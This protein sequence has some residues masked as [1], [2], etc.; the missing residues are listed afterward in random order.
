MEFSP[1][2]KDTGY[3]PHSRSQPLNQPQGPKTKIYT[4]HS[5][6]TSILYIIKPSSVALIHVSVPSDQSG[7]RKSAQETP[8]RQ[9]WSPEGPKGLPRVQIGVP[10]GPPGTPRGVHF[11]PWS[12]LTIHTFSRASFGDHFCVF[13]CPPEGSPK[14]GGPKNEAQMQKSYMDIPFLT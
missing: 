7:A 14:F 6:S 1:N 10:R 2:Y 11:G 13:L 8:K 9:N 12:I 5:I 3:G 4:I